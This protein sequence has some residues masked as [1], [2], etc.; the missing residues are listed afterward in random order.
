MQCLN[1]VSTRANQLSRNQLRG[2]KFTYRYGIAILLSRLAFEK[3][4]CLL[5]F[6]LTNFYRS[7]L[8]RFIILKEEKKLQRLIN[9]DWQTA[10]IN[11]A[12]KMLRFVQ[13]HR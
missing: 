12:L 11:F 4:L 6:Q 3:I 5:F 10:K 9:R 13:L 8:G 7:Y 1:C 2:N